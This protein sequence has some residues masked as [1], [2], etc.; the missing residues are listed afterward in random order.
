MNYFYGQCSVAML[1]ITEDITQLTI[2]IS[3]INHG[4]NPTISMVMFNGKPICSFDKK[5]HVQI[6][7]CCPSLVGC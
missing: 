6:E 4:C 5:Q 1:V 3:A 7:P 2:D